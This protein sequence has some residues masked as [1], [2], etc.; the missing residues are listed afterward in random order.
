[1]E[2][3]AGAARQ[4]GPGWPRTPDPI[5]GS[6]HNSRHETELRVSGEGLT[7]PQGTSCQQPLL[8]TGV[9]LGTVPALALSG[10]GPGVSVVCVWE[11][12]VL[13][14]NTP[15]PSSYCSPRKPLGW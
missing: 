15:R 5:P 11:E 6:L 3:P 1:M 10:K 9:V 14:S 12:G 4:A 2:P 7:L 8:P 13:S